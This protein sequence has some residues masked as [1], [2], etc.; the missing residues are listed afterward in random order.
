[1]KNWKKE[2]GRD[3][4]A[5][6]S[7]PFFLLVMARSLTGNY[8]GFVFQTLIALIFIHL[9]GLK[10][11]F[12]RHL[13]RI[14]V[15]IV[16]TILFYNQF[17]FTIFAIVVGLIMLLSLIYLKESFKRILFGLIFGVLASLLGYYL[18]LAI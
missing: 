10:I 12:N 4:L 3:L 8:Y 6:G 13:S 1:M 15:L 7:I 17:I 16:F 9:I 2:V 11:D 18:T 14:F 5:F